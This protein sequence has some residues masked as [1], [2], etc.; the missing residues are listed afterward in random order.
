MVKK[1]LLVLIATTLTMTTFAGCSL[2]KSADGKKVELLR[3]A[4]NQ[5]EEHP[6]HK[7]LIE[8]EKQVEKNSNNEID[9]QV[10]PNEILGSQREAVELTQTGAID[11][12]VASISLLESFEKMYSV[13]NVPYLFDS[14]EHYHSVMDDENIMNPLFEKTREDGFVGLTWYD[15]GI[16]NI[17]TNNKPIEKPEDL[18]GLKI[19]VQQ[20]PTNIKMIELLGGS[21]TPMGFGEV[22]TAIQQN[23]IDGAEN[24]E[25]ALITNK[26]GEVSKYYS[27]NQHAMIPDMLI[28]NAKRLDELSD[29]HRKIILDAVDESN[30]YEREEWEKSVESA[31][32]E[33]QEMGVK[34][35]YPD[36]KPFQEKV[37]PIHEEFKNDESVAVIYNKIRD[38]ASK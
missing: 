35:L 24:N 38:K 14:K 8:F 22:Y 4:H 33:A 17:Y 32:K 9:I 25:M 16:R 3:V 10:F 11:I 13:F 18:K 5:G 15:A 20:S 27:Y 29:E 23:V 12:S 6:I 30:K 19:R 28:M 37:M 26:H 21:A 1:I 34:F 36:I 31:K 2:S 7:A